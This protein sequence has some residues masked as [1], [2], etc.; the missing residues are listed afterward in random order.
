[1]EKRRPLEPPTR[2][3]LG[4]QTILAFSTPKLLAEKK[5]KKHVVVFCFRDFPTVRK[6]SRGFLTWEYPQIIHVS[7]FFHINHPALGYHLWKPPSETSTKSRDF[8]GRQVGMT[9]LVLSLRM[10]V[11]SSTSELPIGGEIH[12]V[13]HGILQKMCHENRRGNDMKWS[14]TTKSGCI[15]VYTPI[16]HCLVRRLSSFGQPFFV[17]LTT[18]RGYPKALR[19][20][21]KL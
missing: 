12:E 1:M 18:D 6:T 7:E 14:S 10:S 13:Y 5:K 8:C 4:V 19:W 17:Q 9:A 2:Q 20:W 16:S 15:M 11:D 21:H 3:H